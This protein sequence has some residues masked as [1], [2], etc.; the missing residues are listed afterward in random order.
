MTA[1]KKSVQ[2][3]IL[4]AAL[5]LAAGC[6]SSPPNYQ[7]P[8]QTQ[9]APFTQTSKPAP[10]QSA[11]AA[12]TKDTHVIIDSALQN[13]LRVVKLLSWRDADGFMRIE[14]SVQNLTDKSQ[15]FDYQVDWF[16]QNGNP[17]RAAS[18]G[19]LPW[20]LL[21]HETASVEVTSQVVTARDFGV[22]FLPA[23]P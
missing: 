12:P 11:P 6:A 23:A 19:Q 13:I 8:Q 18:Y 7:P 14:V 2:C 1:T 15:A 10:P 21:A 4:S 17:L 9:P 22:A 5:T 20:M 3:V 16:D